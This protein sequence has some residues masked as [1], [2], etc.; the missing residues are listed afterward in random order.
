MSSSC[1]PPKNCVVH[2]PDPGSHD[3]DDSRSE[4][5]SLCTCTSSSMTSIATSV[6]R[7]PRGSS[8]SLAS[9]AVSSAPNGTPAS[10]QAQETSD[11]PF[12]VVFVPSQMLSGRHGCGT[13]GTCYGEAAMKTALRVILRTACEFCPWVAGFVII[14]YTFYWWGLGSGFSAF[15]IMMGTHALIRFIRARSSS[16]C[17]FKCSRRDNADVPN[18]RYLLGHSFLLGSVYPVK[19][20][21]EWF[22]VHC[23][24]FP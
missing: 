21:S 19:R 5:G 23:L 2:D 8:V 24:L 18:V 20:C 9:P 4:C 3:N 1:V 15:L 22:S 17:L 6:S 14:Y 12:I 16:K 11:N 7:D 10:P 13:C